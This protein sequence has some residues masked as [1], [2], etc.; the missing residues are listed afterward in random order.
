MARGIGEAGKDARRLGCALMKGTSLLHLGA[1]DLLQP[2][3]ARQAK[4]VIH[5][6][7]LAP[8]HQLFA[9]EAGVGA[10]HDPGLRPSLPQLGND[11]AHFLHRS[12]GS[13]LVGRPQTRAQQ[14]VAGEDIQRQIAVA[15]VVAV[16]ETLRLMAV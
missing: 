2:L 7:G 9:A 16:E 1:D 14:L 3:V 5:L 8:A 6:V 15:A 4:Q 10:Q 12:G 13:V 11:A